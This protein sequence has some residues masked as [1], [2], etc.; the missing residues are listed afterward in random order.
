M[1]DDST[2][3]ANKQT[4]RRAMAGIGALDAEAIGAELHE[5]LEFSLPFE[6]AVP[7]SGRSEF[8]ALLSGMF[9]MF[10][11]FDVTLTRIYDM[12][13]PN[14]LVAQYEGDALGRDKPVEY[15]NTYIGVFTFRDGKITLWREFAN[16][17][18]SNAMVAEFAA[19]ASA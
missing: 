3:E 14:S 9:V 18:I 8:L 5:D 7:D 15:R 12:L 10:E 19:G 6:E 11:K 16:P 1:G 4:L 17:M 2:R 13:D